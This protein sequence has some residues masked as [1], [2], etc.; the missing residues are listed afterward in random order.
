MS[1]NKKTS[2][3]KNDVSDETKRNKKQKRLRQQNEEKIIFEDMVDE[4]LEDEQIYQ[5]L[6]KLKD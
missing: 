4:L 6:K 1:D 2:D 3:K 5:L